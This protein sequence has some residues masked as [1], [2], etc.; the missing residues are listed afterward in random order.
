MNSIAGVQERRDRCRAAVMMIKT[1]PPTQGG[2]Q[3]LPIIIIIII[4]IIYLMITPV[5]S[6]CEFLSTKGNWFFACRAPGC[7]ERA[8]SRHLGPASAQLAYIPRGA[9][10][11]RSFSSPSSPT[12]L[13]GRHP[14]CCISA[15]C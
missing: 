10:D 9:S 11:T 15:F 12:F 3:E 14:G 4:I 8:T 1:R 13:P 5:F 6:I 7:S 2:A